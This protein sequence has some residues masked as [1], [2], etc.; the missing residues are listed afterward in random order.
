[1]DTMETKSFISFSSTVF[2]IW[3]DTHSHKKQ[4]EN[5]R[6][7]AIPTMNNAN[8][9]NG[10]HVV[11]AAP[12]EQVIQLPPVAHIIPQIN[13]IP[14]T[15]NENIVLEQDITRQPLLK[16]IWPLCGHF[17]HHVVHYDRLLA[18][19]HEMLDGYTDTDFHNMM[20]Y[21]QCKQAAWY[22]LQQW[23]EVCYI[24]VKRNV[25]QEYGV[26][27]RNLPHEPTMDS[28]I[29]MNGHLDEMALAHLQ[30]IGYYIRKM[31]QIADGVLEHM[32]NCA[33]LRGHDCFIQ[34]G[35]QE[36]SIAEY[37]RHTAQESSGVLCSLYRGEI[38]EPS[39]KSEE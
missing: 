20:V 8:A 22:P 26:V 16:K 25:E 2:T 24:N 31:G 4:P 33:M 21:G 15:W 36:G 19:V 9:N 30:I 35:T 1:M 12:E 27:I 14:I 38:A 39:D 28:P 23:V 34:G 7:S 10:G 13:N 5:N 17:F 18:T 32:N 11:P 37:I 6:F 3:A 29:R